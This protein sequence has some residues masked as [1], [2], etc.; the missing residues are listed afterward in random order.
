[1]QQLRA[2]FTE[3]DLASSRALDLRRAPNSVPDRLSIHICPGHRLALD[4]LGDAP[5]REVAV[6]EIFE[7][8]Q[9]ARRIK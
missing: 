1:M 2:C 4:L 7:V 5:R 8:K 6:L 9:P 3:A